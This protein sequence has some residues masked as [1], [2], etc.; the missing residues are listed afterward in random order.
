[1]VV[2]PVV[3]RRIVPL[4]I[5]LSVVLS[6]CSNPLIGTWSGSCAARQG[7]AGAQLSFTFKDENKV[8]VFEEGEVYGGTYH[9]KGDRLTLEVDPWSG[10]ARFEQARS[11]MTLEY[12]DAPA[13]TCT[14]NRVKAF[15]L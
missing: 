5:V 12:E 13:Y 8:T 10:S 15:S 1:M 14:L 2:S 3:A 11:E 4:I 9:R 6:A 7:D